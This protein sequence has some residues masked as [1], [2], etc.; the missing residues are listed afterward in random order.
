MSKEEYNKKWTEL[1]QEIQKLNRDRV[2]LYK[3]YQKEFGPLNLSI[4][5]TVS[6]YYDFNGN[7][8]DLK[9]RK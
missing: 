2:N 4:D 6:V 7:D 8:I 5:R 3:Q 1:N 9:R